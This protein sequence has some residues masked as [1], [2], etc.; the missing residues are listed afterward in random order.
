MCNTF[1]VDWQD[2]PVAVVA[3]DHIERLVLPC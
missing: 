3:D 2:R 1:A